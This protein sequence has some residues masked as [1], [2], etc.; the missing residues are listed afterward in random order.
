M[1][2]PTLEC[3]IRTCSIQSGSKWPKLAYHSLQN[4]YTH[5][6]T[7]FEFFR[8][9][10]SQLSGVFQIYFRITVTVSLFFLQN[11]VTGNNFPQEFSR[12]FCKYSYV[13]NGFGI[14]IVMISKTMVKSFI[15][16]LKTA[17]D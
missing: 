14:K 7:I 4:H 10:Q 6:I 16:S 11:A 1:L 12:I 8:E 17:L 13:I 3:D 15:L 2:R 9:L 5:E